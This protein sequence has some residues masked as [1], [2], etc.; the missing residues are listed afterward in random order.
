MDA[1]SFLGPASVAKLFVNDCALRTSVELVFR[2]RPSSIGVK[3]VEE[4]ESSSIRSGGRSCTGAARA[5]AVEAAEDA[6]A[7]VIEVEEI[8]LSPPPTLQ[9]VG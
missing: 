7:A 9:S 4:S 8:T 2:A 5:T 6:A 1:T 3:V